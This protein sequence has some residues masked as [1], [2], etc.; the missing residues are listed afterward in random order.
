MVTF[1]WVIVLKIQRCPVVIGQYSSTWLRRCREVSKARQ[2][3]ALLFLQWI[4]INLHNPFICFCGPRLFTTFT[5]ILYGLIV[6]PNSLK[7]FPSHR[8]ESKVHDY[9][10]AGI[11]FQGKKIILTVIKCLNVMICICLYLYIYI[12]IYM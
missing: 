7:D 2:K 1:R 4:L 5:V 11:S 12:Y 3:E 8:S 10:L 6:K 9:W